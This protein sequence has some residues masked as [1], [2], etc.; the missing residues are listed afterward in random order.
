VGTYEDLNGNGVMELQDPTLFFRYFSWLQNQGY[1]RSFDF[2]ENNNL[3]LS[4]VQA[5]FTEIQS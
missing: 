3:E 4:D 2:N 1:N 5:L